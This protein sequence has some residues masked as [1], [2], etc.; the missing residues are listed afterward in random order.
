[1]YEK[2]RSNNVIAV[3]WKIIPD[4]YDFIACK[5]LQSLATMT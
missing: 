3:I 1:M 4:F 2:H 5:V